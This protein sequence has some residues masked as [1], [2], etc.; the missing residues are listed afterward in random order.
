MCDWV[1]K[2]SM[3]LLRVR[4]ITVTILKYGNRPSTSV[5]HHNDTLYTLLNRSNMNNRHIDI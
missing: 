4:E 5:M 2:Y 1:F 3:I